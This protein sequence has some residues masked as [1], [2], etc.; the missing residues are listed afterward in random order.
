MDLLDRVTSAH[1][2]PPPQGAYHVI[3]LAHISPIFSTCCPTNALLRLVDWCSHVCC[4][5]LYW[6]L[7]LDQGSDWIWNQ[8]GKNYPR[9]GS[10]KV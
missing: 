1:A 3:T 5:A 2:S 9:K 10:M 8:E 7:R 4:V 6:V